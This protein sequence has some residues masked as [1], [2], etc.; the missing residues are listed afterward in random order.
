[1]VWGG[2]KKVTFII[3]RGKYLPNRREIGGFPDRRK[4]CLRPNMLLVFIKLYCGTDDNVNWIFYLVLEMTLI[5][6]KDV[7][8]PTF[9]LQCSF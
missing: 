2:K 4:M 6:E 5:L 8:I 3:L 7:E 1:M 9:L